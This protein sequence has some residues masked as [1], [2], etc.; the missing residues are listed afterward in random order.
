MKPAKLASVHP[1][2]DGAPA[3][4]TTDSASSLTSSGEIY[5]TD[6][7]I[8]RTTHACNRRNASLI[9]STITLSFPCA[10]AKENMSVDAK[11]A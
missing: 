7:V 10:I 5:I 1:F 4:S 2:N 8:L 3:A 11:N 6:E 9:M